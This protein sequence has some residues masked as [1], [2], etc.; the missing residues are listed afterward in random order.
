MVIKYYRE[1][2][3]RKGIRGCQRQGRV[4][5]RLIKV[6]SKLR[7]KGG[8]GAMHFRWRE[9]AKALN[10]GCALVFQEKQRD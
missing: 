3:A 5:E 6:T 8:E 10:H 2:K 9:N 4:K 1:N 7:P